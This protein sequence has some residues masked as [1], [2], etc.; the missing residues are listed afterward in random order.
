MQPHNFGSPSFGRGRGR[1]IPPPPY[2]MPSSSQ[3]QQPRG[4]PEAAFPQPPAM[5]M[6]PLSQATTSMMSSQQQTHMF[7]PSLLRPGIPLFPPPMIE[8]AQFPVVEN[9]LDA[10]KDEPPGE[11]QSSGFNSTLKKKIRLRKAGGKVWSDAT[12]EEWPDDDYRVFCGDLGNEVTDELLTNAFRHFKSFQKARV[13]RD[14][15]TGKG[16]GFG[17][18]S[19]GDPED[20]LRAM[21]EMDMKYVG[22]RPIRVTKSKWK[23]R[24]IGSERNK[25]IGDLSTTTPIASRTLK[26]FKIM[27]P[28]TGGKKSKAIPPALAASGTRRF[29]GHGP[30]PPPFAQ[31]PRQ[32]RLAQQGSS[33]NMGMLEDI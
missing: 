31:L 19:F 22:N 16:K 26:K 18:V 20:M 27:K 13:I 11:T 32:A 33:T 14:R 8:T 25:H 21:N 9:Q 6:M 12:L 10:D 2:G 28:I 30:K 17:F 15:R 7:P 29:H 4:F 23:D 1:G 24:D 5:V 3:N